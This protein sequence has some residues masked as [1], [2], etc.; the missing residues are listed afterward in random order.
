MDHGPPEP[1]FKETGTSMI[2]VF[3]NSKLTEEHPDDLGLNERQKKAVGYLKEHKK[4]TSKKYSELFE[5]TSRTARNDLKDLVGKDMVSSKG[6]SKK[7]RHYV[8]PEIYRK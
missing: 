6:E 5:I 2:V 7:E 1:E 4:I 8:L 3:R